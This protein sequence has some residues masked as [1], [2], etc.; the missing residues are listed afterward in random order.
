MLT[1]LLLTLTTAVAPVQ[2]GSLTLNNARLTHGYL[3]PERKSSD[4]LPGEVVFLAFDIEN[5]KLDS[6]GRA[7]FSIALEVLDG[8]GQ[9]RFRE[10]PRKL[11]ARTYLGGNTLQGVTQIQVPPEAKSGDYTI[12]VIVQDTVSKV[13]KTLEHKAR[14]LPMEFGVIHV[15]VSAD[16][17]GNVPRGPVG[18]VGE[19]MHVNFAVIGFQRNGTTKQPAVDVALRVTDEKGKETMTQPLTGKADRDIPADFKMIPLQFALTLNRTGRFTIEVSATDRLSGKTSRVRF[20]IKVTTL[21]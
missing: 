1:T 7:A 16:R 15:N 20:P 6:A 8:A 10:V 2:A 9:V 17:E 13:S 19:A 21:D 4:Y 5:T 12:R 3:G 11:V 14:V 18:T